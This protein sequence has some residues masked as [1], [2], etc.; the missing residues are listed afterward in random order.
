MLFT[1]LTAEQGLS[2]NT[3][4]TIA[5]DGQGFMWFGTRNGLNRYDGYRFVNYT[6]NPSDPF[7]ISDNYINSILYDTLSG[8][9]I[10]TEKGLNRF[11]AVKNRFE[12]FCF[13]GERAASPCVINCFALERPGTFWAGTSKGLY[14]IDGRSFKGS[15]AD[16][17]GILTAAEN[18]DIRTVFKDTQ[19]CL[20]ISVNN[21]LLCI[22]NKNGHYE[23]TVFQH[24]INNPT[25]I[26]DDFV[27][28]FYED[29]KGALWIGTLTGLN[30]YNPITG[31]FTHFQTNPNSTNSLANNSIRVITSD[32]QGNLWIGTQ[33]GLTILDATRQ[34]FTTYKY[35]PDDPSSINQNSVHSIFRDAGGNMWVGTFYGGVNIAN[36]PN[37]NAPVFEH[38]YVVPELS[39]NIISSIAID[40]KNNLWVGTEGGG[41]NSINRATNQVT[42]YKNGPAGTLTSNLVKKIC[43]DKDQN[44]WVGT[45]GG[46]LN[47]SEAGSTHLHQVLDSLPFLHYRHSEVVALLE[48]REGLLWMGAHT[49]LYAFVRSKTVLTPSSYQKTLRPLLN[50]NISALLEDRFQNIWIGTLNGLYLFNRNT[51]TISEIPI[52]S[53]IKNINCITEDTKGN[54]WIGLYYGG[55]GRYSREQHAVIPATFTEKLPNE[56]IVGLL[57]DA[58]N[59]LWISTGNGLVRYNP[60]KGTLRTYNK[61]D[62][63]PGNEFNYNAFFKATSG[64]LFFGGMKGLISLFPDKIRENNLRA[65]IVFTGLEVLNV[66]V[67][68]SDSSRILNEDINYIPE[69]RLKYDENTF[70]VNFSLLNYI[71]SAK[72][73]YAYKLQE[74]HKEWLR[75]PTPAANFTNLAPGTY[76]LLIKGANNDGVWSAPRTLKIIILPPVWAT[77]WAYLLYLLAALLLLFLVIRFFYLRALLERDHELQEMKLNFFTN[78]SHEIRTHLTLIKTPVDTMEQENKQNPG[79][80]R[81]ITRLKGNTNRLLHLVSE[82]MDFRKAES[83]SMKLH[84]ARH[85]L[86]SFLTSVYETFE[87]ISIARK[88]HTSFIY[89]VNELFLYFDSEQMAKVIFNLLSNAFKF[90]PDQGRIELFAEET[91]TAVQIHI[92]DN[93]KGIAPEYINKLF[94]NFF[95]VEDSAT[96]NTGYGIGLALSKAI[97]QLHKGTLTVISTP[98]QDHNEGFTRFTIILPKGFDHFRQNELA[99]QQEKRRSAETAAADEQP[100]L[101]GTILENSSQY[102]L[103]IAEDNEPLRQLIKDALTG[104]SIQLCEDGNKAWDTAVQTIPDIIISDVMM[105]EMDG[106]TLCNQLKTDERTS[107]IPIILLTAKSTQTDHVTGLMKGADIYL[108]KPFNTEVLTLSIKNLL[109]TR[110]KMRSKFSK[111]FT[112]A[113]RNTV[114]HS[115][116]QAFLQKLIAITEEHLDDPDFGVESLSVKIAMSQSVLYKK[117]RAVTDM[118]V[119]EFIKSIRLKKAAQLL[120][121]KQYNVS[122]VSLMVGFYDRKYFSREFKKQFGIT[123]SEYTRSDKTSDF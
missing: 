67:K 89:T 6:Y 64:E 15:S 116:D 46:G 103:L 62:G 1:G 56:N 98:A 61:S 43:I 109:V 19:G 4:Y 84:V 100:E 26:S 88:I 80:L 101:P 33:D 105:P 17:L 122:E 24:D 27:T 82:L 60:D 86:I 22:K 58:H 9:W 70:T 110:E 115:A 121:S 74:V 123:P 5:Q 104:Y 14:L 112:I 32:N 37:I 12:R 96:Q 71:K 10:G 21:R 97:V 35:H 76:T 8:L 59:N 102:H 57:E 20:W 55:L 34:Q 79:L 16:Q 51:K 73:I 87:D 30:L 72:N 31:G 45:H 94:T 49:G 7:S 118:S 63:L 47:V 25:S 90:T 69:L 50:K 66:P 2:Q 23:R 18:K 113:P 83:S 78:I 93:G 120:T 119:N 91:E 68:P 77:W 39:S 29:N 95:Q 85:E 28:A 81:Q 54:I 108:T 41:L 99:P 75:T 11:N 38:S 114:I 48:D 117:L 36:N 92:T 13:K 65:P 40:A 44:I 52:V 3:V 106:F 42:V 53:H 107:H 111:E